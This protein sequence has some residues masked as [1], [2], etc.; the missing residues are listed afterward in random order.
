MVQ[1][2]RTPKYR[3]CKII[4]FLEYIFKF[5]REAPTLEL[6]T[7]RFRELLDDSQM[8]QGSIQEVDS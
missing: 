6:H 2:R 1:G 5:P 4:C 7:V 8:E 3:K